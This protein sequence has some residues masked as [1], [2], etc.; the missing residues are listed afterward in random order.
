MRILEQG[1]FVLG[2][3]AFLASAVVAGSVLG[4]IFWRAGIALMLIDLVLIRLWP[5]KRGAEAEQQRRAA[6]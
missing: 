5:E 6:A 1:L 3:V 4:D 2:V